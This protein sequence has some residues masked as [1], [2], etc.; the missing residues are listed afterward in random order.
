MRKNDAIAKIR[1]HA[2]EIRAKG[3]ASL[4]VFGS[5]ARD[6]AGL[7][8]DVD[9]FIEPA[10]G[11]RFSIHDRFRLEDFLEAILGRDIDLGLKSEL[12]PALRSEILAE[13]V[14]VL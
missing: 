8:S 13:A 11:V 7:E 14:R 9:I 10:A 1:A 5:T 12:H 2:A 4:Y 3:A 6:E